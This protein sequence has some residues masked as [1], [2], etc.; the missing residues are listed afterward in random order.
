MRSRLT[1]GP[2]NPVSPLSPVSPYVKGIFEN[3]YDV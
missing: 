1:L 2:G 3:R